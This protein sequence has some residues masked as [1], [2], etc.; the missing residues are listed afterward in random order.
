MNYNLIE[1]RWIPVL[2]RD[3]RAE[4]IGIRRAFEEANAIRQIAATNP[5]DRVA[6]VRFLLALLFWCKGNPPDEPT[7]E[8]A[9]PKEWFGKIEDNMD[10][11]NLFG[12]VRRLYQWKHASDKGKKLSAN[13][14][15]HEV[16]TGTNAWH[17]RHATEGVDGLCPACCAMGLVRL[18]M[19]ATSG[20]TGKSPGI[21]AKPPVYLLPIGRSLAHTLFLSWRKTSEIDLGTPAWLKPDQPLPKQGQVPLL[22][23]LTWLPRRVWLDD[24]D[25][26]EAICIACGTRAGLIRHCVFAGLGSAKS[27]R[28][29]HDPHVIADRKDVLRAGDPLGA[30]DA[31]SG[32]WA[33]TTA[34]ILMTDE[35]VAP[36]RFLLVGFATVKNDK[37]LEARHT[38][39]SFAAVPGHCPV[40]EAIGKLDA[41]HKARQQMA[42]RVASAVDPRE[43][44]PEISSMVAAIRPHVEHRVSAT[45]SEL[46]AGGTAA[47]ESAA[48]EYQPMLEAMAR[49]LAPGFTT[50]AVR[51]RHEIERMAPFLAERKASPTGGRGRKKGGGA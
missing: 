40:S 51:R 7:A 10:C 46:I 19:F 35:A 50:D 45:V 25:Q 26:S 37:Y 29:W 20:G 39:Y 44:H 6:I 43:K 21:N 18:P 24:P 4:R 36:N 5:M 2:Y 33:R 42:G 22:L 23:G 48:A 49:S 47:W 16:P 31:A 9:F 38:E 34:A 30:A 14:L 17:F 13:Y 1:E 32:D 28:V 27:D 15:I 41:W 11:F 3:G 12:Q 8:D